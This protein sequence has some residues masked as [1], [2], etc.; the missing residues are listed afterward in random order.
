[1]KRF[2]LPAPWRGAGF[3]A[4]ALAL[5]LL[6]VAMPPVTLPLQRSETVVVFDITQ[7][8]DV[9]DV[10]LDGAPASRLA[11]AREAARR[12]LRELP[13][14]SRVG[15]AAFTEYRTLLLLAPIEVCENYNDLLATLGEIDGRMRWGNASEVAKGVFWAL[16]AA[17]DLGP[18]TAVVFLTDGQEAPPFSA[19]PRF[20]DVKA[21]QVR[22]W[23]LGVGGPVPQP[24]PRTDAEGKRVGYWRAADVQQRAA[25]DGQP[26]AHEH[27]S[28]LREPHLRMLSDRTGL[29]YAA[30]RDPA[31]LARWM[32][33]PR[34]AH[35]VSVPTDLS[36]VPAVLALLLL[37]LHFRPRLSRT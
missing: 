30:L 11:F 25:P 18:R 31:A 15:W 9:E 12:A 29:A 26:R 6:A 34:L 17:R 4:G 13:C 28:E 37:V 32:R 7:S 27:L 5:L 20:D 14:G 21:G 22:G 3:L 35:P 2:A 36:A 23:L 8:M 10:Q 19:L 24:I 16:R 33:D 1:M